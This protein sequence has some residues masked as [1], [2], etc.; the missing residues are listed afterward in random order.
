MP[1][2]IS[3]ACDKCNATTDLEDLCPITV[4]CFNN[5]A[6]D[7][8]KILELDMVCSNCREQFAEIV[9]GW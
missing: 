1:K 8:P 6:I 4:Y 9:K 5:T 2:I 7:E 3:Y